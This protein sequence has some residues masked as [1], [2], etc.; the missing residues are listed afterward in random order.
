MLLIFLSFVGMCPRFHGD[1][2]VIM[3]KTG[4][5]PCDFCVA[6]VNSWRNN[7]IANTTKD[8]FKMVSYYISNIVFAHLFINVV[9]MLYFSILF[10][11]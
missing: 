6:V 3:P 5:E 11:C 9:F 4:D 1:T 2:T 7:L 10:C 8:E